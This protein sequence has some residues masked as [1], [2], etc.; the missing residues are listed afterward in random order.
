MTSGANLGEGWGLLTAVAA[1][2]YEHSISAP[3]FCLALWPWV[4]AR[5]LSN[6]DLLA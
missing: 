5:L 6:L 4:C 1:A 2:L 3:T